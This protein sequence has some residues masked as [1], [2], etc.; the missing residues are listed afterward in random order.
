MKYKHILILCFFFLAVSTRSYGQSTDSTSTQEEGTPKKKV[1]NPQNVAANKAALMS[2][3]VPGLGQFHNKRYWK[4]PIIYVGAGI[5]TY[6]IIDNNKQYQLYKNGYNQR[7][8]D[9]NATIDP[10]ISG[11]STENLRI[12]RDDAHRYRDMSVVFG[13]AL[14]AINIIDAYVDRHLMEFDV[15]DDL[16]LHVKPFLYTANN[17]QF[18]SGLTLNFSLK[19]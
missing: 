4:P 17:H 12:L 16:S 14:Y 18:A 9:P 19:K 6:F 15:S 1:K 10:S 3:V 13:I 11:Y 7:I 5:I 2:A 8:S